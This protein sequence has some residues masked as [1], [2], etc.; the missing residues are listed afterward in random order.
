MLT[1]ARGQLDLWACFPPA[2]R[3]NALLDRYRMMM[4]EAERQKEQRFH[5]TRDRHCYVVTR[6]LQRTV[7]SRYASIEPERWLFSL[8]SYGKPEI[9]NAYSAP[10]SISF[11]LSHTDGLIVMGVTDGAA[12]GVDTENVHARRAPIDIADRFFA[13]DEVATIQ[14][15]PIEQQNERFFSY[16]TLKEAYIKACAT[17]LSIPLDKFSID[18]SVDRQIDISFWP[19][20]TDH[21]DNWQ[22]KQFWLSMDHLAAV[23]IKRDGAINSDA[24]VAV[25]LSIPLQAEILGKYEVNRQSV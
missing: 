20:L 5:F 10:H 3:A 25:R 17:G 16:W 7:L 24:D 14:Q 6:A 11:N 8:N 18:L 12:L 4:S 2:I 15:L 1:L 9:S 13:A 23:C 22:L 19:P 21:R